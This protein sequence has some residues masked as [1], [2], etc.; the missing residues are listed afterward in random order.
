MEAVS[1]GRRAGLSRDLVVEK[2]VE[3]SSLSGVEGWSVRDI[4]RE[5]EV[6]PS[7]IYHYFSNK[8]AICDAVVDR[9]CEGIEVPDP[10]LDWKD[11]FR[12][13]AHSFR[14]TLLAYPGITD[15]FARGKFTKQFLPMLDG[16]WVKLQEAGFGDNA[17][18][19]YTI[20]ANSLIHTIG[21][22]NLRALNQTQPRHDLHQMLDRFEPLKAQSVGLA[23]IVSSYLEPLSHPEKEEEMSRK[24]YDL[25]LSVILDGVEHTFL[26]KVDPA[27]TA[28]K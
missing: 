11:W 4:A 19:V 25:V 22:R 20:I 13:M 5:L 9:V 23:N 12:C 10:D 6:V 8:E 24:Y 17:A 27:I 14:P 16:A 18:V 1:T 2:A 21:A 26:S 3:L 15:R 7:V 28:R